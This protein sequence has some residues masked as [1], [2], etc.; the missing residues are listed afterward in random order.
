MRLNL[1]AGRDRQILSEVILPYLQ[2]AKENF[3][4]ILDPKPFSSYSYTAFSGF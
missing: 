1:E 3:S 4:K 2:Q